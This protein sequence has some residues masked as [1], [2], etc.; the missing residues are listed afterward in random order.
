MTC[1]NFTISVNPSLVIITLY[2]VCLN[3]A[4]KQRRRFFKEI[5]QFHCTTCMATLQHMNPCSRG[6]EISIQVNPSLVITAMHLVSVNYAW[7]QKRRFVKK[8]FNFSFFTPNYLPVGRRVIK[9]TISSLLTI[10]MLHTKFGQDWPR[11]F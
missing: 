8:Y 4:W 10:K 11:N 2:L 6:H 7:E 1:M 3:Y 9:L 5:M